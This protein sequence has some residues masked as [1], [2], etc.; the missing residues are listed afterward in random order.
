MRQWTRPSL[1]QIIITIMDG[2]VSQITGVSIVCSTI[3]SGVD[4]SKHQG[5]ASLVFVRGIHCWLVVGPHKWPVMQKMFQFDEVIMMV[6]RLFGSKAWS[7][8]KLP[9]CW[10]DLWLVDSPH[11]GPITREAFPC[12]DIIM[13][14]TNLK[15]EFSVLG[16]YIFADLNDIINK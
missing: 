16:H 13:N 5:S 8:H 11:K 3:C 1:V 10:L 7:K 15:F 14:E 12:H 6:F 2:M 4:Q 9:Y